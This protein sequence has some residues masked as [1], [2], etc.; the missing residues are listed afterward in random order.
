MLVHVGCLPGFKQEETSGLFFSNRGM[1]GSELRPRTLFPAES[2]SC[3]AEPNTSAC[4]TLVWIELCQTS[5]EL[6]H[7]TSDYGSC[8]CPYTEVLLIISLLSAGFTNFVLLFAAGWWLVENADKQIAWFPASYL[9]QISV[10]KDIQN[11]RSS[12]EEGEYASVPRH[13]LWF[14]GHTLLILH[15]MGSEEVG[16][17]LAQLSLCKTTQPSLLSPGSLYFVMRAYES[18]KAD[19]LSLNKGVVVEVVRRSDNGWWLIR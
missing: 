13:Q 10:H 3:F 5:T 16:R 11:V 18:Q 1:P 9:E 4:C 14:Q 2:F 17:A 19:E 8:L 6:V 12:D 7:G 15:R